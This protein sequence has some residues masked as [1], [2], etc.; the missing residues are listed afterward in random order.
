MCMCVCVSLLL[1]W[2]I[3]GLC[4][5][6]LF[7]LYFIYYITLPFIFSDQKLPELRI[8]LFGNIK[9]AA[10]LH[11]QT[12]RWTECTRIGRFVVCIEND[13]DDERKEEMYLYPSVITHPLLYL[14]FPIKHK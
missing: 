11:K 8:F 14:L 13:D 9:R 4:N 10:H 3:K 6:I 2:M 12:N 7:I 1:N 5:N